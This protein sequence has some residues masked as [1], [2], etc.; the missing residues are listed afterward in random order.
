MWIRNQHVVINGN[1][2]EHL[3]C[4]ILDSICSLL[5]DRWVWVRA[6]DLRLVTSSYMYAHIEHVTQPSAHREI[7]RFGSKFHQPVVQWITLAQFAVLERER[8]RLAFSCAY[9]LDRM[10]LQW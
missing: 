9:I 1:S 10:G 2:K 8:E 5:V 7:Q 4:G 6:R 3:D